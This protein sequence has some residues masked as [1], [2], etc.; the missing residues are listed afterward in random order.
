MKMTTL[1]ERPSQ[2]TYRFPLMNLLTICRV[3]IFIVVCMVLFC[4]LIAFGVPLVP[5]S[6]AAA[7]TL[8]LIPLMIRRRGISVDVDT[9]RIIQWKTRYSVF[10][11]AEETIPFDSALGVSLDVLP[12]S[13]ITLYWVQIILAG[14]K[15]ILVTESK[16]RNVARV[17]TQELADVI[18]VPLC[19]TT[20]GVMSG[21]DAE[22]HHRLFRNGQEV[23]EPLPELPPRPR[24]A[25]TSVEIRGDSLELKVPPKG[26]E[27]KEYL[28]IIV[29][30]FS[31]LAVVALCII[32]FVVPDDR[33]LDLY[34]GLAM[35][36]SVVL[37]GV[38]LPTLII[39]GYILPTIRLGK[40]RFTIHVMPGE[41]T[42]REQTFGKTRPKT[43]KAA[44][45]RELE[46]L[47]D[48]EG[49]E[50]L[51]ASLHW[52]GPAIILRTASDSVTFG[53]GLTDGELQWLR[54][55]IK[56]ALA[57][58]VDDRGKGS[59]NRAENLEDDNGIDGGGP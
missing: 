10:S 39:F 54:A 45:I 34:M 17:I 26:L 1:D 43:I 36:C 24:R 16:A 30:V 22:G 7:S 3:G 51:S 59:G 19:D 50:Y 12:T 18:G 15:P 8:C 48:Q 4:I 28:R 44:E 2:L 37:M 23:T 57:A 11:R 55:V 9:R 5:A 29:A 14:R 52:I 25:R 13:N 27:T 21:P 6:V 49:F 38:T 58:G 32:I 31:S 42:L 41:L 56:R 46:V 40:T 20:T 53:Q 33:L 35:L 47:A